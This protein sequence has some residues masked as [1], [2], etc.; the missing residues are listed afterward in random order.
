MLTGVT[1]A[2]GC[3]GDSTTAPVPEPVPDPP[4]PTSVTV[5]P[6]TAELAALGATVQ[7]RAEVRDQNSNVMAGAIV[8]WTSSASSVAT[9]NAS[10]LVTGVAEGT[11]TITAS[12]GSARGMAAITVVIVPEPVASVEVSPSAET[13]AVG[14]TLQLT[15]EAFDANGQAVA[16]AEF[17]W[18]SGD[19]AVA[20]VDAA[21]LVTGVAEGTATITASS[22]SARGMAAITV[23]IVPE[24]VASVEVSPSA[25]TIAV[26][27]T[28]QLTA[29]AFDANGQAVAGAEF[30][31]E[32]G[33]A[34][35]AKVD[36]AGL[37]TGVAEG[38]ATITASSGSARGTA[39]IT[40][41]IVP[42]PVAS[43][44]VSPSAETIAVGATLQLTAEAFDANGQAVAGAE[45]SWESGDVAVAK[46]DVAGLVTGVAEGTATITASAGSAQG[47]A[48]IMVVNPV[49]SSDREILA[50]FYHATGG[51][52]WGNSD[53]WLTDAPLGDWH[54]VRTDA[55]GR[56]V[57]LRLSFN[58]LTGPIPPELGDLARLESMDLSSNDLTGSIPPELGDLTNL[59]TLSLGFND[60][61]GPLPPELGNLTSLESL[62]LS[63]NGLTGSIPQSFLQL[64]NLRAFSFGN[65]A[66][67][68]APSTPDFVTWLGNIDNQTGP[69]C[70]G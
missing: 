48:E 27:A 46:V 13:I 7:L 63:Y 8:T 31:W 22:G 17:S 14:A 40:V 23:V 60:L 70:T 19:A 45:F 9:V 12:S 43:V 61:A 41:V 3:G 25:E 56:V 29:E 10:G 51:P 36:A 57:G 59:E 24:P 6:A 62:W 20:K 2:W 69:F 39:A 1:L 47:T 21:G 5:S 4:R 30:S 37:V 38:T 11:A 53:N 65:N 54:G 52:N 66:G 58:S 32:S 18:E 55:S 16:G 28:L 44:E 34:A 64:D 35:V 42:E 26:G 33:D 68:C 15:A 50:A 49:A 67:L